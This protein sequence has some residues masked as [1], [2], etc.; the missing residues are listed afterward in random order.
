MILLFLEIYVS[1]FVI[2]RVLTH[3]LHDPKATVAYTPTWYLRKK[4]KIDIHHLHIGIIIVLIAFAVRYTQGIITSYVILLAIGLSLV[5]DQFAPLIN[6]SDYFDRKGV[7]WAVIM[8][9]LFAL[10]A[11]LLFL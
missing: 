7:I 3:L 10:I 1:T 5:A 4:T 9:I 2:I 6:I 8:H 11:I